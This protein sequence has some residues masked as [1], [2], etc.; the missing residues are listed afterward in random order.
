M[1][2]G[3]ALRLRGLKQRLT[4]P[5]GLM[6]YALI[7]L[8][9]EAAFAFCY[10]ATG[11]V[12]AFVDIGSD[13]FLQFVPLQLGVLHQ[14]RE[15][16]TLTWSFSLGLGGYLG[17]LLDPFWLL[18]AWLP[19]DWQLQLRLPMHLM[20]M[21][22][23]GGFLYAYL[24]QIGFQE[25]LAI[26]GGMAYA[27]C[28]YATINAQWE[29]MHGT[30]LMQ[31]PAYLF[32]LERFRQT[33]IRWFGI[34]A[35]VVVGIGHPS[36][37]YTFAVFTIALTFLQLSSTPQ[38][39]LKHAIATLVR[40]GLWCLVGFAITAPILLPAFWYLLDSPRVSGD[41][42]FLSQ[43]VKQI[44]T[45]NDRVVF[46]SQIG[47]LLGKDLFGTANDYKGWGNYF[48]GPGFYV[49]LLPLLCL[50]QLL[51]SQASIHERRICLLAL[52]AIALYM[53][54][55]ALRYA[56]F[57][58]SMTA[59]RVST[60]WISI[61]LLVLGLAGLRRALTSGVSRVAVTVAATGVLALA[62]GGLW[63]SPQTV[64]TEHVMRI[65]GFTAIYVVMLR[66]LPTASLTPSTVGSTL[67]VVF[68]CEL[69][70]FATP[71]M[72]Q[73]N[74]VASDGTSSVGSYTDGTEH[75]LALVR[76][77]ETKHDLYRV[78]KTY[79]SVFLDDALMQRYAGVQSYYHHGT[80]ITRFS[81]HM[82]LPKPA[83]SSNYIG[84]AVGRPALLDL[85]AVKYLLTRDRSLENSEGMI[86]VGSAGGVDVYRNDNAHR[87]GTLYESVVDEAHANALPL[88]DRDHLLRSHVIVDDPQAIKAQLAKLDLVGTDSQVS[89][90]SVEL[91]MRRDDRL[92]G[93][94]QSPHAALLL[95]PMPFDRG[96]SA[97]LDEQPL[98]LFRVDY[99]LTGA[100][101]PPGSHP[102]TLSFTPPGRVLGWWLSAVTIFLLALWS[103]TGRLRA[104]MLNEPPIRRVGS[105]AT[106]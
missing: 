9:I 14:L 74:A 47:G 64:N 23:G 7:V 67:L 106:I 50:P 39:G 45:F 80:S 10:L 87:F 57:A 31:F 41:H 36:G 68:A 6:L 92:S 86:Y 62:F 33:N 90:P 32:L 11:S 29:I 101:I 13:T 44:F 75:A 89:T 48:E 18:T 73:R 60:L 96:W 103:I 28:A 40:F 42:S 54:S 46:T 77:N 71:A 97:H 72:L 76:A 99:G 22:I 95:L 88:P 17:T 56:T 51:S 104:K 52:S 4:Q 78:E 5:R 37:L 38:A 27:L 1:N 85:L 8:S 100:L 81:D 20:R 19:E 24:R 21:L 2:R 49:G 83:P 91:T 61:L 34:A 98:Q 84:S 26:L 55:P 59:F 102:I 58:F 30:E 70:L 105:G 66:G 43:I 94:I 16:G 63:L 79:N 25:R 93:I 35:G 12:F 69:L 82:S 53:I 15:L 3:P 65:A